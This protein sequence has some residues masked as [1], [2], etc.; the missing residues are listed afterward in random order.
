MNYKFKLQNF[1]VFD[2]IGAEF[3]IAPITILTGCNSSGKSSVIKSMMLFS[4]LYRNLF[5]DY[6]NGNPVFLN[7]YEIKF[8]TGKHNLGTYLNTISKY[9]DSKELVLSFSKYSNFFLCMIQVEFVIIMN[10]ADFLKNGIIKNIRI[11]TPEHEIVYL[12]V[13]GKNLN[14]RINAVEIKKH[15]FDYYKCYQDYMILSKDLKHDKSI[16]DFLIY[17][18]MEDYRGD[19]SINHSNVN[20]FLNASDQIIV[21]DNVDKLSSCLMQMDASFQSI[22]YLPVL[23]WFGE[24]DKENVMELVQ[25]KIIE[26]NDD[27]G[28]F[29]FLVSTIFEMVEDFKNSDYNTVKEYYLS[30]ENKFLTDFSKT[31]HYS[32]KEEK[33]LSYQDISMMLDSSVSSFIKLIYILFVIDEKGKGINFECETESLIK[34]AK[35]KEEKY[36]IALINFCAKDSDFNKRFIE[37]LPDQVD[38]TYEVYYSPK[39]LNAANLFLSS[40]LQESVINAPSFLTKIEFVDAVKANIQRMYSFKNQGT[41]FNELIQNYFTGYK[42]IS[43]INDHGYDI[44]N[45]VRKWIKKFDI[46]DDILYELTPDGLGVHIYIIKG[47]EKSLLADEGYGFTQIL[48]ILLQ[49]EL[50]IVSNAYSY[51]HPFVRVNEV[52]Y[53]E[54]TIAI[55]EPEINLHPKFQ[56]MLAEM[57]LDAYKTYNIRFIIE[58]HSEYLI[59]K[60]QTLVAKKE[61]APN[62][63]SLNYIYHHDKAMRPAGKPQVLNIKIKEDGRLNEP[64]GSGFFDEAD[65]LAMDLLSLKSM[66]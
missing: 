50:N 5:D 52:K 13:V 45:F 49:I 48:A 61:M 32:N 35:T 15:L 57:F 39:E 60:L 12:E 59:R 58:T 38:Q 54:S 62:D 36:F 14:Y 23:K 11:A 51:T 9:S 24:A 41:P 46:G 10:E 43:K 44:G 6:V 16:D 33:K 27:S 34:H 1:R 22:F 56:S 3:D 25:D 42:K 7:Q 55:E 21:R 31:L 47:E 29:K 66:N 2:A 53:R 65:N 64:F 19:D 40:F 37:K 30:I 20:A 4:D 8:N 28:N 26:F 18:N 17:P 63:I